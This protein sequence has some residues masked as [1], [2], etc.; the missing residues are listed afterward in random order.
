MHIKL[1]VSFAVISFLGLWLLGC[2]ARTDFQTQRNSKVMDVKEVGMVSFKM[3]KTAANKV[4][5]YMEET[6][7][8]V[9]DGSIPGG[10]AS[11]RIYYIYNIDVKRV[12][13]ITEHGTVSV[14]RY[15]DE[16]NVAQIA[17]GEVY[18]IDAANRKLLDYSGS[19]YYSDYEATPPWQR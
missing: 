3:I 5:G 16:G 4:I 12:G 14:Y 9:T 15:T 1:F 17:K 6:E 8:I 11:Q 13:F 2:A 7:N 10:Q 18:T 19:I